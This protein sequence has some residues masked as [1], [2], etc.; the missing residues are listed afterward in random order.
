MEL[1][2]LRYFL[3]IA[4]EASITRAA[5]RL[6]IGQP[7]L[8]QQL[9]QLEREI[10]APLFNR[11]PR[12]VSLTEAGQRLLQDARGILAQV[13]Q[14]LGNA[15][16]AARGEVGVIRIGFTSSAS[17]N[18]FVTSAIRDYSREHP[19]VGVILSEGTTAHLLGLFQAQRLDAAFVRPAPGETGS[20]STRV[21]FREEMWVALPEGHRLAG[22]AS[23]PLRALAREPFI[24]YPR[25]NGRALYDAIVG[26][27]QAAGFSPEVGQEAPQMGSTV[28]LVAAGLGISIVPASMGHL[29]TPG[30]TYRPIEGD[31]PRADMSLVCQDA[32]APAVT[33]SFRDLVFKRLLGA[34]APPESAAT[35]RGTPGHPA[36][37]RAGGVTPR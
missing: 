10:G 25:R 20:L 4:E 16:R 15:R 9:Q 17:F 26:A 22:R 36:G 32:P 29:H 31:A 37:V 30:V 7:P 5:A 24:L 33:R 34:E 8:S 6:G 12:G 35:G 11:L 18:P 14:A 13:D 2:H 27:C 3:A 1:R 19:D 21:L 23:V 28:T